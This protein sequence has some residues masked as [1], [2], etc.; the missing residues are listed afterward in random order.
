[1]FCVNVLKR[2]NFQMRLLT[3]NVE[4]LSV[5]QTRIQIST[6]GEL[7]FVKRSGVRLRLPF[8]NIALEPLAVK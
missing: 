2:L 3:L 7:C 1:M 5:G 8:Q 6:F 4:S